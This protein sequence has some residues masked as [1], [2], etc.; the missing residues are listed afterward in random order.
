MSC[1]ELSKDEWLEVLTNPDVT[2]PKDKILLQTLYE[3]P[4][5]KA[6]ASDL[7]KKLR[8]NKTSTDTKR[9]GWISPFNSQVANH[10]KRI[11]RS[12]IIANLQFTRRENGK[13][14]YW[15]F[16]FKGWDEEKLFIWQ[17]KPALQQAL[18]EYLNIHVPQIAEE[19]P[20]E[21]F[22]EGMKQQIVVNRYERDKKARQA[23]IKHWGAKCA[24][25]GFVFADTYGE[26]GEGFIHIHH[27][28]PLSEITE[29]YQ[30][31]PIAHLRPVCPNCHAMLHKSSP[32]YS[33]EAL[34]EVIQQNQKQQT[35]A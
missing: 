17:L 25:C 11:H 26:L 18:E 15:D 28:T 5:H 21:V 33:I 14:K 1:T 35:K 31:D 19:L 16:F 20:N 23:C 9:T 30:V 8:K 6:V 4:G 22:Y 24:V 29:V 7:G 3:F 10:A 34:Q 12:G 13:E 32:P 2:Y 27:L